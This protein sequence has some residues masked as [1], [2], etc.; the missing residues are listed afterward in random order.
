MASKVCVA[1]TVKL[2]LT[3]RLAVAEFVTGEPGIAQLKPTFGASVKA[4]SVVDLTSHVRMLLGT[5][6]AAI[7][8]PKV[9]CVTENGTLVSQKVTLSLVIAV[10]TP[11]CVIV[12]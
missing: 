6:T 7:A 9:V 4:V 11:G 5:S 10:Q 3:R 1:G 2:A 8:G 12:Y